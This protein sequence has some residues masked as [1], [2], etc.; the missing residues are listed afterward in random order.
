MKKLLI[1]SSV[2]ALGAISAMGQ[3]QVNLNDGGSTGVFLL[4]QDTTGTTNGGTAV[5]V[6]T[7]A[8]TAGFVGAGPGQVAVTVWGAPQGTAMSAAEATTPLFQGFNS[9]SALA[10]AQGT[11]NAGSA[12]NGAVR[13]SSSSRL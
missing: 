1:L 7:A 2:V 11:F 6:G 12:Y 5:K 8:N 10:G 13:L 3:G 4:I 9:A